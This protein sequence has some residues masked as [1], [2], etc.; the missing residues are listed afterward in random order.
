MKDID[1]AIYLLKAQ[2]WIRQNAKESDLHENEEMVQMLEALDAVT[3]YF[4]DKYK[5]KK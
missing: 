5:K 4:V 3:S 1:I 2:L